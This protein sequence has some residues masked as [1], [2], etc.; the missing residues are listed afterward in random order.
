MK[1]CLHKIPNVDDNKPPYGCYLEIAKAPALCLKVP[2][3]EESDNWAK[4]NNSLLTHQHRSSP[5]P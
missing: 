3:I 4:I 1:S 2:E 5:P